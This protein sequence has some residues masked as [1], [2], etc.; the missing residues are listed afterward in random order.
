MEM[1]LGDE[2][3]KPIMCDLMRNISSATSP[4]NKWS[5]VEERRNAWERE[6]EQMWD[7]QEGKLQS[8]TPGACPREGGTRRK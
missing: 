5:G 3:I 1:L 8:C 4:S 6:E 7:G 2:D